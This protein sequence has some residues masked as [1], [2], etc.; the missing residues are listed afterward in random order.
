LL[1]YGKRLQLSRIQ[2]G[3]ASRTIL[4]FQK[5]L[6]IFGSG[7]HQNQLDR[8]QAV[9]F[10]NLIGRD[11]DSLN[12][13]SAGRHAHEDGIHFA[14]LLY[15]Q[16]VGE[17]NPID[18]HEIRAYIIYAANP[19]N[20]LRPGQWSNCPDKLFG[21]CGKTPGIAVKAHLFQNPVYRQVYR[22]MGENLYFVAGFHLNLILKGLQRHYLCGDS[23]PEKNDIPKNFLSASG[24]PGQPGGVPGVQSGR[25]PQEDPR[26]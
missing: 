26:P 16:A 12:F 8:I 13:R 21:H 7:N 20:C 2:A 5:G 11:F 9:A 1:F 15:K 3:K 14:Q 24:R 10:H 22:D 4:P 18:F 23:E 25:G 17:L 6:K 19:V